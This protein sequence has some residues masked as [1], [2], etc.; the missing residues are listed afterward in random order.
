MGNFG[1][2]IASVSVNLSQFGI[3]V[4]FLLVSSKNLHDFLSRH[5]NNVPHVCYWIL[6]IGI[7]ILP[8]SMLKSPEDFWLLIV[9]SGMCTGSVVILIIVAGFIDFPVCHPGKN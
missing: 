8:L 9:I 4:V 2:I 6:M 3:V 7:V 5:F 1:K